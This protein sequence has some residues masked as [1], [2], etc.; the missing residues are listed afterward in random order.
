MRK[1]SHR[2]GLNWNRPPGMRVRPCRRLRAY[3]ARGCSGRRTLVPL[4]L[5][6]SAARGVHELTQG[7]SAAPGALNQLL[8][9]ELAALMIA[10]IGQLRAYLFKHNVHIRL[11]AFAKFNHAP[12]RRQ[13]ATDYAGIF[14]NA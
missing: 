6:N 5:N 4:Q 2:S 14:E 12:L 3:Q 8:S 11:G 9:D 13:D 1:E 10:A 7:G